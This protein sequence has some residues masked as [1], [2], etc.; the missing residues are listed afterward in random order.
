MTVRGY[1]LSDVASAL[2]KAIRRGDARLA[3]YFAIEMFESKYTAYAWRRLLTISAEDCAGVVTKEIMALHDA[4]ALIDK[5][6]KG[7]GRVFLGKATI[8][9]CQHP[10]SRDAD[11]LSILVYDPKA[12]DDAV[13]ERYLKEARA[14]PEPIPEYAYDCHTSKGKRAGKTKADFLLTEQDAL[15]PRA[16]GLFD[17][18]LEAVRESERLRDKLTDGAPLG[19]RVKRKQ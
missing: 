1:Q 16:P 8:L 19:E 7:R 17:A 6:Q 12:V 10:K 14:N 9:L 15:R 13:V 2:Q 18:D 5:A 11:H 4:W 3:G